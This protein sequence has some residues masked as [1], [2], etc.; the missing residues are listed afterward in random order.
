MNPESLRY[1][2]AGDGVARLVLLGHQGTPARDVSA[3][4]DPPFPLTNHLRESTILKRWGA[5]LAMTSINNDASYLTMAVLVF[6]QVIRVSRTYQ[7]LFINL[8]E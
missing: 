6:K 2:H 8:E 5:K 3:S 7:L 4:A 1:C